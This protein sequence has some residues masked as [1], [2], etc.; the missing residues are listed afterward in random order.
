MTISSPKTLSQTSRLLTAL[1][2]FPNLA[3]RALVVLLQNPENVKIVEE[4][5]ARNSLYDI[6]FSRLAEQAGLF[7][8]REKKKQ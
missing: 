8:V 7:A 2:H 1:E 3:H 5:I 4:L 6:R